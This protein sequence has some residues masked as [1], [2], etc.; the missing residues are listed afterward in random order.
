MILKCTKCGKE[1]GETTSSKISGIICEEC[2]LDWQVEQIG[3]VNEIKEQQEM[4][5]EFLKLTKEDII[6][7]KEIINEHKHN[8][9]K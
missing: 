8:I 1:L 7:L 4:Q 5:D 9:I 6:I 3:K 2:L